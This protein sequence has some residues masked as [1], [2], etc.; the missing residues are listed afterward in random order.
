MIFGI[1][2]KNEKIIEELEYEN[3]N[4]QKH[5]EELEIENSKVYNEISYLRSYMNDNLHC[6]EHRVAKLI[7]RV[8]VEKEMPT[9]WAKKKIASDMAEKLMDYIRFDIE[10]N[11]EGMLILTGRIDVVDRG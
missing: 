8:Y 5:V 3:S 7:G 1:K 9:E 6:D 11:E 4:L 10:N 2:T